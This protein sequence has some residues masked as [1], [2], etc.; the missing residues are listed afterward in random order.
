MACDNLAIA[1][2]I[3]SEELSCW[4]HVFI[5]RDVQKR[6]CLIFWLSVLLC[7]VSP[8]IGLLQCFVIPYSKRHHKISKTYLLIILF[9]FLIWYYTFIL[10]FEFEI[11]VCLFLL[12]VVIISV[13]LFIFPFLQLFIDLCLNGQCPRLKCDQDFLN[14]ARISLHCSSVIFS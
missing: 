13:Y 1:H 2:S 14:I 11:F 6:R 3:F 9:G 7:I 12:F 4:A 8:L 10:T 5:D